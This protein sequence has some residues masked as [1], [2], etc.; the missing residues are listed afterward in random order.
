ARLMQ[1]LPQAGTMAAVHG[2]VATVAAAVAASGAISIAAYNGPAH[3]VIAGALP[4]VTA[5]AGE[6][7]AAGLAGAPLRVAQGFPS[8]LMDPM[9]APFAAAARDVDFRSPNVTFISTVTARAERDRVAAADY[10]VEHVRAP[11]QF[12][13]ALDALAA[14]QCEDC[15]EI[16]P[17]P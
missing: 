13:S 7:R 17:K 4:E 1:A 9:L 14:E 10:W 5:V 6:L 16:G 11:V 15:L 3:V 2:P 8:A 12:A